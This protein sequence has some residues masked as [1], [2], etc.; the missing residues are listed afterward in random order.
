[1]CSVFLKY[2]DS[3]EVRISMTERWKQLWQ[4]YKNVISYLFFGGCTTLVN[5]LVYY[6]CAYFA[7]MGTEKST[8][9]A[10]FIAVLFAYITNKLFV[11]ESRSFRR[12]LLVREI[13]SFFFCRLGTGILD[14]AVMYLCVERLRWYDM[15]VKLFSNVLVIILNYAASKWLIF[16]K[17]PK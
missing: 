1:M 12:R 10:W 11:F 5:L 9:A 13:S 8:A 7:G 16:Q 15:P 14:L 17:G 3:N 2:G 6:I 4:K